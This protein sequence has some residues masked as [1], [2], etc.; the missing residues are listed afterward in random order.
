[1]LPIRKGAER[2]SYGCAP[3]SP[4]MARLFRKEKPLVSR[5]GAG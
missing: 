4:R 2:I 5:M 1:V 3:K